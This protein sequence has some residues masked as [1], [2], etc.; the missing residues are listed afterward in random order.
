[1]ATSA[2]LPGKL[3][4]RRVWW[5]QLIALRRAGPACDVTERAVLHSGCISLHAP[6]SAAPFSPHSLQHA[7]AADDG[8]DPYGGDASPVLT[9]RF[10]S[11]EVEHLSV[12]V[13]SLEK[14]LSISPQLRWVVSGIELHEL[15][16]H[17]LKIFPMMVFHLQLLSPIL[18]LSFYVYS[19]LYCAKV[20]KFI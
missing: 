6:S 10:S 1:M 5:L 9:L 17:N 18:R 14:R 13:S 16:T 8:S 4:D 19:F 11:D 3:V 7:L 2:F 20:F 12:G 15:L